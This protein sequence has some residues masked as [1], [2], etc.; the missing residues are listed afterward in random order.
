MDPVLVQVVLYTETAER[1][2]EKDEVELIGVFSNDAK[3]EYAIDQ[4]FLERGMPDPYIFTKGVDRE[5]NG[6]KYK[7]HGFV[8]KLGTVLD[9]IHTYGLYR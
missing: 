2:G 6:V 3:A 4:L 9:T 8:T 5:I 7:M 1:I